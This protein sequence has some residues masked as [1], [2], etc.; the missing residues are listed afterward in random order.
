MADTITS[1]KTALLSAARSQ[2]ISQ[3]VISGLTAIYDAVVIL[4][5]SAIA[6]AIWLIHAPDV[7]W[8]EYSV[9]PLLGTVV[10]LNVF[11]MTGV[12]RFQ[13]LIDTIDGLKRV[14]LGWAV[15]ATTLIAIGFLAKSSD[16]YSRGW[17]TLWFV[18][19]WLG[20]ATGR[21]VLSARSRTWIE[22]GRLIRNVVVVGTGPIA[23]RLLEYLSASPDAGVRVLGI[24]DDD[25]SQGT[26]PSPKHY[27]GRPMLGDLDALV[28]FSR[29]QQIDTAII[30]LPQTDE[31]RLLSIIARLKTLPV[32]VRLCSGLLGFHLD[33]PGVSYIG[34][35][36]LLN[37]VNK[38]LSDWQSVAKDLEDRI[39][40]AIILAMIS[41]ILLAIAAL[42]KLDSPGP[43]F[44]RQKRY[45]FNN[46][47]IDVFKFRTMY[48][49]RRDD[50]AEQLTQRNDPRITKLGAFLRKYS[51]DELPQFFNVLRGEMSIVGP[52]PH[53]LSA[54]AA[55]RLYDEAVRDYAARHRVKPGIT[56]WA[57]VN[58]W[59]GETETLEQI[60]KRVEHD[61]VYIENWSLWLDVKI[62]WMTIFGGFTGRNAF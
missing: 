4:G 30:A 41:P 59:R 45:G 52:R 21:L 22:E 29:V 40:A 12:Y 33:R 36:P 55:G 5:S 54:K 58:G 43:V 44:F 60:R 23:R 13:S 57:Q 15:V 35:L 39:A 34:G 10:A 27:G 38:P 32:D 26:V 11:Q 50:N 1:T 3:P 48:H 8:S 18:L 31:E 19:A 14:T 16:T 49:E 7:T 47:L 28:Q 37:V 2:P 61:L 62:I 9:V 56:G 46:Q 53:A 20:L 51:L 25:F 17:S 6:Y 42:I 24:F